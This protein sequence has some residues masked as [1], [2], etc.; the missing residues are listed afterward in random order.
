MLNRYSPQSFRVTPK[1][2]INTIL[3]LADLFD[4]NAKKMA[5]YGKTKA[6]KAIKREL[7]IL[8]ILTSN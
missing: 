7:L 8:V 2:A 4:P 3:G 1:L 5:L 6:S